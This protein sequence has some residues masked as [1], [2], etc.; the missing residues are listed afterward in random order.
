MPPSASAAQEITQHFDRDSGL[1]ALGRDYEKK[2][3]KLLLELQLE[4]KDYVAKKNNCKTRV[5][6]G[7]HQGL[8]LPIEEK[9]STKVC[10]CFVQC[11]AN[12]FMLQCKH[13]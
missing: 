1:T 7:Q 4:Y 9:L 13:M 10:D 3:Q 5:H 6:D 2:K 8:S 12:V 11:I